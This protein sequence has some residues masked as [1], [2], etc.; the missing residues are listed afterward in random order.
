LDPN[1]N[2]KNARVTTPENLNVIS[3]KSEHR[4]EKTHK[5]GVCPHATKHT[6]MVAWDHHRTTNIWCNDG[7]RRHT[8][9]TPQN[10][11]AQL[12]EW[13]IRASKGKIAALPMAYCVLVS[14]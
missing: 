9:I 14:G 3:R 1:L 6:N 11:G 13:Q 7:V 10:S 12:V 5:G 4:T 2:E 8:T